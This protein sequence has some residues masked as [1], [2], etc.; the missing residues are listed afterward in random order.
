[1]NMKIL[2]LLGLGLCAIGILL[3]SGCAGFTGTGTVCRD[4]QCVTFHTNAPP[5]APR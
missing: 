3:L 4:G 1:M 5:S 2:A